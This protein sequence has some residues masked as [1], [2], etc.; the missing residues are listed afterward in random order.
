[1]YSSQQ[2]EFQFKHHESPVVEQHT[3]KGKSTSMESE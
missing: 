2:R 3:L 1:M